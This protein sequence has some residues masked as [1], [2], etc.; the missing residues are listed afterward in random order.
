MSFHNWKRTVSEGILTII[1]IESIQL[2][3]TEDKKMFDII[4][5]HCKN[6]NV[7][8]KTVE[9]KRGRL[10]IKT[11]MCTN[12]P[13]VNKTC[14]AG[15]QKSK[16]DVF[17]P[18]QEE[19]CVSKPLNYHHKRDQLAATEYKEMFDIINQHCKNYTVELK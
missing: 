18:Q 12:L 17:F 16:I 8:L 15:S 14:C 4:N 5:Q 3:A 11:R 9:E 7:A 2:A 19:Q 13:T 1:I 10:T 6:H